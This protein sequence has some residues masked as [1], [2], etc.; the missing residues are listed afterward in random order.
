MLN[1]RD[2]EQDVIKRKDPIWAGMI[3]RLHDYFARRVQFIYL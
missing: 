1:S 3:A 2:R